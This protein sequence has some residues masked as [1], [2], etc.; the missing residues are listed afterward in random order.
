MNQT[1]CAIK[2]EYS[3]SKNNLLDIKNLM[4]EIKKRNSIGW[5]E[6]KVEQIAQKVE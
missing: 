1:Q 4:V 6:N 5:L 2:R 3:E